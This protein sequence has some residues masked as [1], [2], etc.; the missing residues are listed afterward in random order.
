MPITIKA[1]IRRP[2]ESEFKSLAYDVMACLFQVH[3]EVAGS[4][5][6]KSTSVWCET[7]RLCEL[8]V[9]V[10]VAFETFSRTYFIDMLIQGCTIFD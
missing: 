6:R 10:V 5:T 8:E 7:T 9:P 1:D 3:N 4:A 2:T